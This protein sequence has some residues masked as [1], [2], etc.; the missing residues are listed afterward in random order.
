MAKPKKIVL[1]SDSQKKFGAEV[2]DL[3][4]TKL[5]PMVGG[6]VN[7]GV[8]L[9]AEHFAP[10]MP[11]T[12]TVAELE[13][14][15]SKI[16][17]KFAEE[18]KTEKRD[19]GGRLPLND[20]AQKL[21]DSGQ[22]RGKLTVHGLA[23]KYAAEI[24]DG[25]DLTTSM[26]EAYAAEL[27]V[28]KARIAELVD[29]NPDPD[30]GPVACGSPVHK[31]SSEPF[32][33]TVRYRLTRNDAGEL[34]RMK[35]PQGD[36]FIQVGNF[37][38]VLND[39]GSDGAMVPYCSDCREAGWAYGREHEEKVTFYTFAGAKR[40]LD[41]TKKSA[42]GQVALGDQIKKAAAR[43]F[44]GSGTRNQRDWRSTRRPRK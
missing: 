35:H 22:W 5:A 4:R 32:Q 2:F 41:A 43:I 24:K 20:E 1:A 34:V 38:V 30:S 39:E 17:A 12:V 40:K 15:I 3:V 21:W 33:P 44:S 31:G 11:A 9:A 13:D 28:E 8:K 19:N 29:E 26:I 25:V 18:S 23:S 10:R 37:L 14:A 27:A 7:L 42:E 36:S 16:A 6:N